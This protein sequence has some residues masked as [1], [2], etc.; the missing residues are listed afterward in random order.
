MN[1]RLTELLGQC[2]QE[3]I[4]G[5][6]YPRWTDLEK[7]AELI[8]K[9]CITVGNADGRQIDYNRDWRIFTHFG[10]VKNEKYCD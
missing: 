8:I 7:F 2:Q 10:V 3:S 4:D 5:P 9:E 1:K 6:E